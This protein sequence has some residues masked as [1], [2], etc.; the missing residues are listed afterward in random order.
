MM[1]RASWNLLRISTPFRRVGSTSLRGHAHSA[2]RHTARAKGVTYA[3]V[4]V[5]E[6]VNLFRAGYGPYVNRLKKPILRKHFYR[7]M[8]MTPTM[9]DGPDESGRM[10]AV[11]GSHLQG[12]FRASNFGGAELDLVDPAYDLAAAMLEFDCRENWNTS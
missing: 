12:G 10:A 3:A 7:F 1:L 8:G 4:G 5:D 2:F 6:I 9:L 11:T